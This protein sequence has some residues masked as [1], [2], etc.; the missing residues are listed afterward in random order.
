MVGVRLD[1]ITLIMCT[2]IFQFAAESKPTMRE[3]KKFP[4]KSG[5]FNILQQIGANYKDFGIFLLKDDT[6]AK[7]STIVKQE[8]G[9]VG[10]IN[11]AIF[12]NWIDGKGMPC[13]W[14]ILVECLRDVELNVLA[15]EIEEVLED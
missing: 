1:L 14:K 15:N 7:T 3:L 5:S 10:E 12:Q 2:S 8:K 9:D 11:Q 4:G 13:T 6:G